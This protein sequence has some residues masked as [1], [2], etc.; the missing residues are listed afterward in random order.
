MRSFQNSFCASLIT[1]KSDFFSR[2][3]FFKHA[4]AFS[5]PLL[6]PKEFEALKGQY[7]A[8][9]AFHGSSVENWHCI[10]NTGLRN[11]SGTDKEKTGALFGEVSEQ[12]QRQRQGR[13]RVRG[14]CCCIQ[15]QAFRRIQFFGWLSQ[16]GALAQRWPNQNK[17]KDCCLGKPLPKPLLSKGKHHLGPLPFTEVLK[18]LKVHS[19]YFFLFLWR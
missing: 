3:F 1:K 15:G 8:Q 14:G 17:Y 7:G 16:R 4:Y 10:V 9:V 13:G 12:R 18:A 11:F 2:F 5:L 19:F 6:P